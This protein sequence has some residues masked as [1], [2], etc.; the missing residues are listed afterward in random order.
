MSKYKITIEAIGEGA[1]PLTGRAQEGFEC[2]GMVIFALGEDGEDILIHDTNIL[3]VGRAFSHSERLR[4]AAKLG[5]A[6]AEA[7]EV[8]H[9]EQSKKDLHGMIERMFKERMDDR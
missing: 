1:S 8:E 4:A 9:K 7:N 2:D 5:Q 6:M 3:R